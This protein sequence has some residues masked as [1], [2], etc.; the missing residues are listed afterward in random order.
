MCFQSFLP[1]YVKVCCSTG[2]LTMLLAS[3][4]LHG[5][6]R[7]QGIMSLQTLATQPRSSSTTVLISIN[8]TANR[9][10]SGSACEKK[11]SRHGAPNQVLSLPLTKC[12]HAAVP[13]SDITP[14]YRRMDG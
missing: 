3:A 6:I 12:S 8:H 2:N 9:Y 11:N 10:C 13:V 7:N 1:V 14:S 4:P 5:P